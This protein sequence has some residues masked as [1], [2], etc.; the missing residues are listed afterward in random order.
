MEEKT[1]AIGKQEELVNGAYSGEPIIYG[2]QHTTEPR[3][4]T[5]GKPGYGSTRR[6]GTE[7]CG[8]KAV[9]TP[10]EDRFSV[11]RKR[12]QETRQGRAKS[13]TRMPDEPLLIRVRSVP[14]FKETT[15]S[16]VTE[17]GRKRCGEA[18][19]QI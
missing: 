15:F 19:E 13:S 1:L 18:N 5:E 14:D 10:P 17:G 8:R 4:H 12:S 7:S 2:G 9:A 3:P 6:F 11:E 16:P